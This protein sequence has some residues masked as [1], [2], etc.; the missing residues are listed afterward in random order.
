MTDDRQRRVQLLLQSMDDYLPD[1]PPSL[2]TESGPAP[3]KRVPCDT[4]TKTGRVV[5][6][7]GDRRTRAC[8]SCDG[9]G[10]RR[11]RKG[12]EAFDEYLGEPV[13]D[14]ERKGQSAPRTFRLDEDIRRLGS[15]I[16]RLEREWGEKRGD[17]SGESFPW[18]TER[19]R[20]DR[21]GSYRELRRVLSELERKSGHVH[22]ST[23]LVYGPNSMVDV[24][25]D[26]VRFMAD[27]GVEY[28]ARE[29][30]GDIRIPEWLEERTVAVQRRV[31]IDALHLAGY[32]PRKIAKVLGLSMRTVKDRVKELGKEAA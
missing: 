9:F 6:E 20:L 1:P 26:S 3:S 14:A 22:R 31:T 28:I 19:R 23:L 13:R 25:A 24:P 2:R 18:E 4:C 12:D 7:T 32:S 30:R 27:M 17:I 10:W 8:P 29:M 16:D 5:Y 15:S 21:S 11:R